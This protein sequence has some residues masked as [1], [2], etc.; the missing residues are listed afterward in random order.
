MRK[1]WRFIFSRYFVSAMMI[2]FSVLF[3]CFLLFVA[4]N[5]SVYV[6]LFMILLNLLTVISLINK[7]TN[8]EFKL[9][10][11]VIVIVIP[12]FGAA[13]YV[14]FYSRRLTR[15]E[16]KLMKRIQNEYERAS[17]N[18][19]F[20][21]EVF[22]QNLLDVDAE[23][24]EAKGKAVAILS[25]D[26]A[27][28]L[29][30]DSKTEYFPLGE[31]M[32]A[33]MLADLRGAK[34]YIFLEYFIVEDGEM[35]GKIFAIL[36][37]KVKAGLDVRLLYDDIGSMH[38]LRA[39]FPEKLHREGIRCQR[40][41]KIVPKISTMHHNRD[42]R[43]LC[44]I[45]GR[46]AYTGGINIA[47]EYINRVERFG[48]WK[49]GG[50]RVEGH[51][52]LG[53]VRLFVTTWD[54]TAGVVSNYSEYFKPTRLDGGDGGYY[55]PFGSG[56][57]P[58]YPRHVGKNAFLNLINQAKKYIYITTPYLIIDYTLTEALKCAAYRGVDVVII[59]PGK[60]DKKTVK[61]MTKSA[62]P[63]LIAAGVKIYE[64]TPGFIHEKLLVTDDEYAI[65]GTINFDY[66][67]LIHHF[68]DALWMY[69]T[70]TVMRIKSEFLRT[71][72]L[73]EKIDEEKTKLTPKER[74][75]KNL[76]RIFAPL[77]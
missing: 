63:E 24:A 16:T 68:E 19:D 57:A 29:Y 37:E 38:T 14:M 50:V 26:A 2:L 36:K 67:S 30:R 22:D 10:W 28:N 13:I 59:T 70:P 42:H 35:W 64:Y 51:A 23:S 77:L 54:F 32:F 52:V 62:Y 43:K 74:I 31:E 44:I 46:V 71:V 60:A 1:I 72:S 17:K 8:P 49:D 69:K 73:S 7:E 4:Y 34:K 58:I 53:F 48:H 75:A 55:I 18:S 15:K 21:S 11:M 47:D 20:G 45:D 39:S 76:I 27:S 40:F 12:I 61:V 65:V 56:P 3:I 9:P 25:D 41:G 6:Y 5:Y 33:S 66:R